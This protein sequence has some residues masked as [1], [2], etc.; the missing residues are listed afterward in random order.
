MKCI[1]D[2]LYVFVYII[3]AEGINN[4]VREIENGN[5]KKKRK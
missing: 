4:D 1:M 3:V 5:I 2:I